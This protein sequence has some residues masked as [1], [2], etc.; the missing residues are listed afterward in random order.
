MDGRYKAVPSESEMFKAVFIQGIFT[1]NF[2]PKQIP[3]QNKVS[4]LQ[5]H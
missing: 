1:G 3:I 5:G 4:D 2:H